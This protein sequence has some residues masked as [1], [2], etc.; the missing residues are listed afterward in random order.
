MADLIERL[1]TEAPQFNFFALLFQ[2][3]EYFAEKGIPNPLDSGAIRLSPD[4]GLAFPSSDIRKAEWREDSI[5]LF[6]TFM[7]LCGSVSPLPVYF[8]EYCA[9]HTGT[10][11]AL[12]DF[13]NMFNHRMYVL[14]YRAWKK[15]RLVN[16]LIG[17]NT[18]FLSRIGALAGIS[19]SA[20][21]SQAQLSMLSCCG[22]LASRNRGEAGLC[23]MLSFL[24]ENLPVALEQFTPR[25]AEIA[26]VAPLGSGKLGQTTMLGTRIPDCSGKFRLV[27]GP[28]PR[29]QFETFLPG[30]QNISRMQELVKAYCA[31]P[32]DFDIKVTLKPMQLI[33]IILG[34]DTAPLGFASSLGEAHISTDIQSVVIENN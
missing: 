21:K 4:V 31:D 33:P 5:T 14:F 28:L 2:L 23:T 15:Y 25:Y 24:F 27:I 30:T 11:D 20:T 17:P 10:D 32:L 7:G 22:L 29:Q 18:T 34:D 19:P 1:Q 12:Y 13:L 8:S 9:R 3:E 6:S 26:G 16:N